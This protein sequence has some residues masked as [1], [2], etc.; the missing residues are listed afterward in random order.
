MSLK[1]YYDLMSQ[2][3]RA[4]VL[5]CKA[6]KIPFTPKPVA[7]RKYEHQSEEYGL[8]SP[9]RKVPVIQ[10][11]DFT[12]TESV[13]ILQYLADRF[14]CPDH[15]YPK[16]PKARG[17][18]Q[19]YMAWQHWNTRM[20]CATVFIQEVI[21]PKA[22][23]NPPDEGKLSKHVAAM[24]TTL[25]NMENFFLKDT[26]YI[27]GHQISIADLL[28]VCEVVQVS[29]SGR[30]VTADHPKIATWIKRVREELSPHFDEVFTVINRVRDM[31]LKQQKS[32]L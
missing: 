11:G 2:P 26:P 5:F 17:K 24:N 13:A 1:V 27:S 10:D 16:D 19:E 31:S 6:N 18:V 9:F 22:T 20:H 28:G 30:D 29:A 32:K 15:W 8:I 12:L 4:V 14:D 7:L 25:T 21:L 23:G 3:A